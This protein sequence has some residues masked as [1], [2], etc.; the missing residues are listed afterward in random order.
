MH[1]QADL[2]SSLIS[3]RQSIVVF[4]CFA[5]AYFFSYGL[6]SVNAAL[7]PYI[8]QDLSLSA[9]Q[10]G[11]LSSAFFVA[12]GVMQAPLGIWLDRYGARRVEACLLLIAALGSF[13]LVWAETFAWSSVGR[14]LIGAGVA[15]SLMAPFS[16]FRRCFPAERQPQLA[17]WLLVAGTGGAVFF[18]TPA[19]ALAAEYGWRSVH[20]GSGVSLALV[21]VVLWYAVPDLD[22]HAMADQQSSPKT[23]LWSLIRH[24]EIRK[25]IALS[26]IGQGGVMALQTLWAG[27][28]LTDVIGMSATGSAQ[29]LMLM[30]ST[31]MFAYVAMSFVSPPLQRRFGLK[32]VA[33][34]GYA[35]SIGMVF[36]LALFPQAWFLWLLMAAGVAPIMLMQPYISMQFPKNTAGRVVTLYNMFVFVGAFCIQWGVGV[37]IQSLMDFDVSKNRAYIVTFLVLGVMQTAS[38][39]WFVRPRR[40]T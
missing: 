11:W 5:A 38:L 19:A 24:P 15:A 1:S 14:V 39:L 32:A 20:L 10:L 22:L 33:V 28:W 12:L 34:T 16:Y 9:A 37:V 31:M 3:K 7:A 13:L 35:F 29:V 2:R 27:P 18:T 6:R 40:Q 17:L 4:S 25:V 36:L 21:A 30:M 26:S 23:S 8:T